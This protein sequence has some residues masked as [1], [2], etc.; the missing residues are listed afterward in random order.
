MVI[1]IGLR[2]CATQE[3]DLQQETSNICQSADHLISLTW[4][5]LI[6]K[7]MPNIE[8]ILANQKMENDNFVLSI[9]VQVCNWVK[10]LE[11]EEEEEGRQQLFYSGV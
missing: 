1:D 5:M 3:R 4:L 9:V 8:E 7:I 2:V 6:Y 11:E 10:D